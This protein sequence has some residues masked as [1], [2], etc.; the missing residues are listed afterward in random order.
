M[1][2]WCIPQE[3]ALFHW[4]SHRALGMLCDLAGP[5]IRQ[6][7]RVKSS[8]VLKMSCWKPVAFLLGI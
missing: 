2:V 7:K 1:K 5:Q 3:E 6:E 8:I 4:L